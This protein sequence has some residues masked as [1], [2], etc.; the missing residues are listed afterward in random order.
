MAPFSLKLE[1][2]KDPHFVNP[3]LVTIMYVD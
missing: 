1:N 2:A 3:I